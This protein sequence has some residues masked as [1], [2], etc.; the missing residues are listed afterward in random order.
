MSQV[1][2]LGLVLSE[3]LLLTVQYG[4]HATSVLAGA[5]EAARQ[6]SAF[7]L[8]W[9][10]EDIVERFANELEAIGDEL[11]DI[12]RRLFHDD[13]VPSTKRRTGADLRTALR[14]IGRAG[15]L[16]TK[17]RRRCWG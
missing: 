1:S 6:G 3:A 11:D 16:V 5:E 4:S 7:V 12:S 9:L 13:A 8:V 15:E 17:L 2:S 14:A 10:L